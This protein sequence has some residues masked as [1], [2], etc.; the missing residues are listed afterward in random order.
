VHKPVLLQE[1][2]NYLNLRSGKIYVDGTVGEGG[3]A[4][5]I[6]EKTKP[7]G[8]LIGIDRDE[9]AIR[10]SK[11][12]L[13]K[14]SQ[15]LILVHD[16]FCNLEKI[17]SNLDIKGIDGI[18]LDLGISTNQIFSERGFSFEGKQILDMRFN[19]REKM[20]AFKI[21]NTYPLQK[22]IQVFQ[23][24]GEEKFSKRIA[25]NIIQERN[26]KPIKYNFELVEII[27]KSLPVAYIKKSKKHIATN[28]FRALRMEVNQ[29]IWSLKKVLKQIPKLLNP[30]GRIAIISF[31]SLED[32]IVKNFFQQESKEC[33]C[34]KESPICLCGHKKR[35]KIVT[36]KPIIP[37]LKELK[38]NPQSRSAKLRVAEKLP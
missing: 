24:L 14:Y 30:Y 22:L 2:I 33:I 7:Q 1:T 36:P 18:L 28:I 27:K 20:T 16:N 9:N 5:L 15:R 23:E 13:S 31:H 32:R 26:K 34:P 21:I 8:L 35:L 25:Q 19:Q 6:L 4:E 17:L 11:K 12:R 38:E 10:I 3:H 37:S 29:E